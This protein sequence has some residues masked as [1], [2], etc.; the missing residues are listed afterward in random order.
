MEAVYIDPHFSL[1]VEC[2]E[3]NRKAQFELYKL[4]SKAMYNVAMRILNN[5][6]EASDMLQESFID[7]FL[8]IKE[9]RQESSF[10]MWVKQIVVNKCISQLRKRKFEFLSVEDVDLSEIAD[11]DE[12]DE[13]E[14]QF[15]VE[16]VKKAIQLLPEGY[17]IVLSLYL[18]E[19]YD[20][21]EIAFIL[22]ITENT[23]RTQLLRAKRKLMD[24]LTRIK[25][26]DI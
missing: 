10:G 16:E 19:G 21:E 11:E 23:S 6:D 2:K 25:A 17:R 12:F 26:K 22:K 9:F 8:R 4:Y 20:H 7:A 13:E 14:L 15:Q 1:V 24:L 18:L 3:G 5:A